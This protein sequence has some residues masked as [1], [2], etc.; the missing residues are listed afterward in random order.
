MSSPRFL[1]AL[2][3]VGPTLQ[4]QDAVRSDTTPFRRGQWAAQFGGGFSLVTLGVLRFSSPRS[5]WVLDARVSGGHG[6]SESTFADSTGD[7]T[8][9]SF[10]SNAGVTFRAGRRFLRTARQAV[11][12]FFGFGVLGG[13]SHDASGSGRSVGESNGWS[14]GAFGEL[15]GMYL[16]DDNFGVGVT[17]DAA[18]MYNRSISKFTNFPPSRRTTWSYSA[19][20]PNIRFVVTLYF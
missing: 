19:S 12:T 15:G 11:V 6:H 20:A 13:F 4:A 2:L 5:A 7:T 10:N 9:T 14:A 3:I 18:V 8:F 16:V 1:V 17:A